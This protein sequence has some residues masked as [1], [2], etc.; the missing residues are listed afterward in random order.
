MPLSYTL[1]PG[2]YQQNQKSKRLNNT[3]IVEQA[4]HYWRTGQLFLNST[5]NIG[6]GAP[7]VV[8]KTHPSL[9]NLMLNIPRLPQDARV[10]KRKTGKY[11][12]KLLVR[13]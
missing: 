3:G 9:I 2:H 8:N 12:V 10:Y 4:V 6:Y 7:E 1:F 13:T 11:G 5:E